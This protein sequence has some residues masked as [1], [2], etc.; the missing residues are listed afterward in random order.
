MLTGLIFILLGLT[1]SV[2]FFL[3]KKVPTIPVE[4]QFMSLI[5]N[6][7]NAFIEVKGLKKDEIIQTVLNE[8]DKTEVKKGGVEGIYLTEDK[9]TIGLRRFIALIKSNFQPR[10]D[11]FVNDNFL[12]GV[13]NAETKNFFILLKMR[14]T[15]DIFDSLR[16]WEE[17]MFY[18][19]HGFFGI[20]ISS[21]TKYLLTKNFENS[22]I[23][24]KNARIL[25]DQN[26]QAVIMYILANDNSVIITGAESAAHEIMLR[27]ASSQIKK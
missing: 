18:N 7:R 10:A 12:M 14:S 1:I 15:A 2:F 8:I 22:M 17:K 5:F 25:Y 16:A 13:V 23:E 21:E 11:V 9:K 27:L 19:L 26:N 24:N 3:K 6:D 4:K 20:N